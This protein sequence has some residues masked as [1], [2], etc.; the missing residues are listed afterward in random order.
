MTEIFATVDRVLSNEDVGHAVY[1]SD[2]SCVDEGVSRYLVVLTIP[3]AP[4]RCATGSV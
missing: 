2:L 3:A 1:G 4:A